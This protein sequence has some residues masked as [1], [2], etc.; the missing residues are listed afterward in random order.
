MGLRL[1][2]VEQKYEDIVHSQLS[3]HDKDRAL[4]DLMT[5]MENE[6]HIPS[7][8]N[9]EWEAKNRPVIAMYRKLLMSRNSL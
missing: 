1:S 7:L 9:A 3:N 5:Q 2:D 4:A 8:Q 6:F